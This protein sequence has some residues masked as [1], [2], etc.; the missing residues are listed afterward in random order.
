MINLNN[1]QLELFNS[2]MKNNSNIKISTIT[3]NTNSNL[4]ATANS[5]WK[6]E[7][8]NGGGKY[9]FKFLTFCTKIHIFLDINIVNNS[10]VFLSNCSFVSSK[11]ELAGS[12]YVY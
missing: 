4:I 11:G 8:N 10:T 5:F 1:S 7:G 2:E 3:L 9:L 6:N 12:I